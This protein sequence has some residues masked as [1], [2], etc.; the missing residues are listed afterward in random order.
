MGINVLLRIGIAVEEIYQLWHQ[1]EFEI[2]IS[3]KWFKLMHFVV[4]DEFKL[5]FQIF[6]D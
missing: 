6:I 2:S 4:N 5:I 3:G 1:L